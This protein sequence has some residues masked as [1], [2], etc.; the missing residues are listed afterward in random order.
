MF[1]VAT[2]IQLFVC[3]RSIAGSLT[4][5]LLVVSLIAYVQGASTG[6]GYYA[7]PPAYYATQP[8]VYYTTEA[9]TTTTTTEAPKYDFILDLSLIFFKFFVYVY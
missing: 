9:Y 1:F 5:M 3:S 4:W 7:P 8:P 2:I 6:G